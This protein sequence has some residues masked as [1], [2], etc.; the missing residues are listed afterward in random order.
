MDIILYIN[1]IP[2]V[3]IECKNPLS[4]QTSWYTA[5]KQIKDYEGLVPELY[6]Y[7]QIGVA[8]ESIARYFPIVPWQDEPITHEWHDKGKDSIDST[9]LMLSRNVLLD[10]IR[11]YLFFRIELGN[12]TK[13]ITRYMQYRAANKM[14]NRVIKNLK[15]EEEKNKGLVWHWQGSGKTLTMIFAAKA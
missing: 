4:I 7:V 3:N 11:N 8:A 2:L 9:A 6:K 15:G 14:V 12:A 13:V 10:I 1:G 5:Y